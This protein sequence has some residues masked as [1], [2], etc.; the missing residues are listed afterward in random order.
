MTCLPP[1]EAFERIFLSRR[2]ANLDQRTTGHS[3]RLGRL[4]VRQADRRASAVLSGRFATRSGGGGAGRLYARRLPFL[5]PVLRRPRRVAKAVF[6]LQGGQF[7]KR[8]ERAP[9]IVDRGVSIADGFESIGHRRQ[10]E[11]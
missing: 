9:M 8:L 5:L 4:A 7:E 1:V 10:G 11:V 3:A 2:A 6:F